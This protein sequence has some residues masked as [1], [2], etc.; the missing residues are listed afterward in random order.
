MVL[1]CIPVYFCFG[2]YQVEQMP[3]KN[4]F[5]GTFCISLMSCSNGGGK[6]KRVFSLR[7]ITRAKKLIF[8]F[9]AMK[10]W[11]AFFSF[12]F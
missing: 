10:H 12:F 4:L 9:V 5:L 11:F 2:C 3:L 8:N 7:K 6:I 1:F